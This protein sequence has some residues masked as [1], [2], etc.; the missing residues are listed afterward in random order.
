MDQQEEKTEEAAPEGDYWESEGYDER[1]TVLC[2]L[3]ETFGLPYPVARRYT[4]E[5][6]GALAS[7]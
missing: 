3:V 4:D 5:W 6:F 7:E 1:A 2:E